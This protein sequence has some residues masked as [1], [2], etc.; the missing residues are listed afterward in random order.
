MVKASASGAEDPGFESCLR[1]DFSRLSHTGNS[2]IGTIVATLPGVWHY[3]VS[4][5]TGQ[6]SVSI[7]DEV[8]SLTFNFYSVAARKIVCADAPL[9]YILACCWDVKQPTNW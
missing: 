5:G 6:P 7:L 2:K 8:E 1:Q 4:V 3:W 9:R